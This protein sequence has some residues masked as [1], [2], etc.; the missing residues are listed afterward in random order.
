MRP[1][2]IEWRGYRVFS[3]PAMLYIGTVLGV[4]AG[5]RAAHASGLDAF[6]VWVATLILFTAALAGA[7]LLFVTVQWCRYRRSVQILDRNKG[8]AAQY[9]GLLV[10]LPL[11]WPL[12]ALLRVPFAEFWD[13]AIITIL[14]GMMFTRIG[15]LLNGCCAGRE[16][17]TFGVMLT[18]TRGE[19]RRRVPTQILESALALTLLTLG[20]RMWTVLPA[21]GGL[22]LLLA[23]GYALGRLLLETLRE[24]APGTPAFNIQHALSA[25]I[26]VASFTTL[27]M[28]WR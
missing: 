25:G 21:P 4:F 14:V 2:L 7:R 6:R 17:R 22:F 8:G 13:I 18:N 12:L 26:A 23:G 20:L 27:A 11:S 19:C 16:M 24:H 1:I 10:A 3:Y 28:L 9:G 5:N 15:C